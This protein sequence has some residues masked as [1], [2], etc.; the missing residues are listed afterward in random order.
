MQTKNAAKCLAKWQYSI[1]ELVIRLKCLSNQQLAMKN[2]KAANAYSCPTMRKQ[3]D[4]LPTH[5]QRAFFTT[6]C[7]SKLGP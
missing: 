7:N 6:F 1:K 2:L 4:D 5:L 3:K